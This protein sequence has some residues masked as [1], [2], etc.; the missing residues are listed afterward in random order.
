MAVPQS[1]THHQHRRFTKFRHRT[2]N[3][4]EAELRQNPLEVLLV[5]WGSRNDLF[6][7]AWFSMASHPSP[8][9]IKL[10]NGIRRTKLFNIQQKHQPFIH[11]STCRPLSSLNYTYYF[12]LE[13][14][15]VIHILVF[16]NRTLNTDWFE[17]SIRA[18]D[19]DKLHPQIIEW[20]LRWRSNK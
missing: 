16:K 8:S 3:D 6:S 9:W 5:S 11:S 19:G 2:A 12:T 1:H 18:A 13:A 4:I 10:D 17:M 15:A 7:F 14:K 20:Y